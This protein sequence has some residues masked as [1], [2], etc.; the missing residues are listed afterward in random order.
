MVLPLY[1]NSLCDTHFSSWMIS[2]GCLKFV[3]TSLFVFSCTGWHSSMDSEME[4]SSLSLSIAAFIFCV[5]AWKLNTDTILKTIFFFL[6]ILKMLILYFFYPIGRC[7][8]D[9]FWS[10]LSLTNLIN[11][12]WII[13]PEVVIER[14]I[15]CE[16]WS[17][18][19]QRFNMRWYTQITSRIWYLIKCST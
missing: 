13:F 10:P 4:T 15:R 9:S 8:C 18:K 14:K 17:R 19:M 16:M 11:T 3:Q 2:K 5:L 6:I 7:V 12:L 1:I